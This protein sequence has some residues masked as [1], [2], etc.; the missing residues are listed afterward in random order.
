RRARLVDRED[1]VLPRDIGRDQ[2]D[3]RAVD[4]EMGEVDGRNAELLRQ[5]LGDVFLRDE[6]KL[7]E[8]LTELAAGLLL[9]FQGFLELILSD[10]TRFRQQFAETYAHRREREPVRTRKC[11]DYR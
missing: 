7:D 8:G 10:Q 6:S 5:A 11:M 1:V 2:L 3:H 4:L 9:E